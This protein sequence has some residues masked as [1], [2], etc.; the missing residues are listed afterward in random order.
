[1]WRSQHGWRVVS[2][3]ESHARYGSSR[4]AEGLWEAGKGGKAIAQPF[5]A[6]Q[7]AQEGKKTSLSKSY[8]MW[9]PSLISMPCM[10]DQGGRQPRHLLPQ[11]AH[12]SRRH[13][14]QSKQAAALVSPA[15]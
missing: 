3:S 12:R 5:G 6:L 9:S 1:M 7:T 11:P 10:A 13:M 14:R 4:A 2:V 15:P 8:W